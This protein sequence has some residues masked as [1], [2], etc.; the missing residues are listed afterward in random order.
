MEQLKDILSDVPFTDKDRVIEM[1]Q[2]EG[3][4]DIETLRAATETDLRKAGL[5]MGDII[6]IRTLLENLMAS[7]IE[8]ESSR[9]SISSS[10]ISSEDTEKLHDKKDDKPLEVNEEVDIGTSYSAKELL[11]K[12]FTRTKCTKAQTFFRNLLRD[13]AREA[14]IWQKAYPLASIPDVKLH[15]FFQLVIAAVPQLADHKAEIRQR[16]GQALSNR[17][18][19]EKDVKAGK[20]PTKGKSRKENKA[21]NSTTEKTIVDYLQKQSSESTSKQIEKN[22]INGLHSDDHD[23]DDEK[24][25]SLKLAF[26]FGEDVVVFK[27]KEKK[28]KLAKATYLGPKDCN[29]TNDM[30]SMLQLK[31]KLSVDGDE[32]PLP[33]ETSDGDT[34]LNALT[35]KTIF[36][37]KT[38]KL[39]PVGATCTHGPPKKKIKS[40]K[41]MDNTKKGPRRRKAGGEQLGSSRLQ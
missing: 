9:S 16:L 33:E 11:K 15:N 20:R 23:H 19:Y 31:T 21:T 1:L 37:W 18:K 17:R 10:S 12:C 35:E 6:K 38:N 25:Q 2:D 41:N 28:N 5:K 27:E 4:D 3:I 7:S 26:G 14:R 34:T 40:K 24:D 36:T 29:D 22:N 13:C 32:I 8:L 30:Y 39:G